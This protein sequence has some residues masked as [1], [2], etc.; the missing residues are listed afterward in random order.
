MTGLDDY[1]R[2]R[3]VTIAIRDYGDQSG[4]FGKRIDAQVEVLTDWLTDPAL[5]GREFTH[6]VLNPQ[7]ASDIGDFVKKS[8]LKDVGPDDVV[9]VYVTGHGI[10]AESGH[11][12]LVLRNSETDR[13][14][15]TCYPTSDLLR[16]ILSS[17]AE[18]VLI[19]IDSCYAGALNAEWANMSKALP[20]SRRDLETLVVIA[21]ADFDET[22]RIGEFAELLR[23]VHERLRGPAQLTAP[24]L[25]L[26]ELFTEIHSVRI[27]KPKLGKPRYVWV[28]DP[29]Y[30]LGTPCLPNPGYTAPTDLVDR[31]RRQVAVTKSE[32]DDYWTSRAAG[33]TSAHD[34]GWYFSGREDLMESVVQFLRSGVGML[35]VTGVA[36]SGKSAI[37]A[38]AV[39]LS[40]NLFRRS[41]P[42]VL[43]G[44]D[45]S[46][47]P[48]EDSIDAAI[49]ARDKDTQQFCAELLEL[50]GGTR[51]DQSESYDQLKAHLTSEDRTVLIVVDG[52]DEATHPDRLIAEVLGPLARILGVQGNPLVRL[53]VG[54]RSEEHQPAAKDSSPG[55]LGLLRQAA[56][57]PSVSVLRTDVKPDVTADIA[58][59]LAALLGGSGPYAGA[60]SPA[61]PVVEIVASSVSPSFLDAR[62]AGERLRDAEIRQDIADPQWLATLAD[63]TLSLFRA[64]LTDTARA[65]GRP[66]AEVLAVLRAT[67]FAQ[68]RGLP[69]AD[70]WPT[71]A[72]AV[73]GEPFDNAEQV[74]LAVLNSRL[75]GYLTQDAA[76][77]RIVYRP[78]HE[79]LAE[80]LREGTAALLA[81]AAR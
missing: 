28:N 3:L 16:A 5:D 50:L 39:T 19:F 60:V 73:F 23:G 71:M 37:L 78:N 26:H 24:Y 80:E 29:H 25:T 63:G 47:I 32:L 41:N 59:Y 30:P 48:P 18:H 53:L 10:K 46:T 8:R 57:L 14:D 21:S 76:D 43:A 72:G 12:F 17:D 65:I 77:G 66:V 49:L 75:S 40:D 81:G 2:R 33:R 45:A 6:E 69:W 34:P 35:V 56:N 22:P 13:P 55:L 9:V 31:P 54:M 7:K 4:D 58:A 67:A 79:R 74:I 51:E 36:G 62:L 38:R 68:G 42:G 64:D 52:V 1:W 11:H 61:D 44:I 15:A 27:K 20:K 70:I